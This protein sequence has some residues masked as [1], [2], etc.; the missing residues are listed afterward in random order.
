MDDGEKIYFSGK[1][2]EEARTFDWDLL[3]EQ[4]TANLCPNG[5]QITLSEL[6]KVLNSEEKTK[7]M[8]KGDYVALYVAW[9]LSRDTS[10]QLEALKSG[11]FEIVQSSF[12]SIFDSREL[13]LVLCG[14]VSIDVN[15]KT[16]N[17][18]IKRR[19]FHSCIFLSRQFRAETGVVTSF[20]SIVRSMDDVN[21]AR[22][23]QL[24]TDTSGVPVVE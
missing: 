13:E 7:Q 20:W 9:R 6:N 14:L 3:G 19:S 22:L 5:D 18:V 4:K 11:L 15:D 21:R 1:N 24:C 8:F 17:M 10:K 16:Q 23:L 12:L 2:E